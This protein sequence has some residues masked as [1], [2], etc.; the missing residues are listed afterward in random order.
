[1]NNLS[2][3]IIGVSIIFI[4]TTLGSAVVFLFKKTISQ[5]ANSIILGFASGVM[6]AA[7]VWSLIIPSVERLEE[8]GQNK[9]LPVCIGVFLGFVFIV[10]LD[11][12]IPHIKKKR[13]L[14][15]QER[16]AYNL[17]NAVT[18]HNIPE[19]LAVG[20]AFG[21]A[22]TVGQKN[23]YYS[24]LA[25]SIGIAIQNLPEGAALSL[26]MKDVLNS[27][28]R[29]FLVGMLSGV[30][31]PIAA[32]IG[33]FLAMKLVGVMPWFLSF[34]AGSMLYVVAEDLI[35]DAQAHSS[36]HLGTFGFIVGFIVMMALD[37]AL[38]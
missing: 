9:L 18:I 29:A 35:P 17:F 10:I 12:L 8:L 22:I 23:A 7:S 6:V 38:G 37:I 4:A 2:L 36:M 14:S 5:N 19:G 16:K 25:L 1:M 33:I 26:P 31:E 32:I 15:S 28:G 13:P 11:R 34:A 3:T 27:K 20:L 30:V 24:A 21:A